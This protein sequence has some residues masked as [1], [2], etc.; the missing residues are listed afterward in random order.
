MKLQIQRIDDIQK[1]ALATTR[2]AR[3]NGGGWQDTFIHHFPEAPSVKYEDG[4]FQISVDALNGKGLKEVAENLAMAWIWFFTGLV[5]DGQATWDE[6]DE[7][8]A[9]ELDKLDLL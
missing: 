3:W 7:A 5:M 2:L 6:I 8:I 9:E 1:I 4:K